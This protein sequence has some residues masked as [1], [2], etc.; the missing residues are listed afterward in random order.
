MISLFSKPNVDSKILHRSS[1][2]KW[3]FGFFF[4]FATISCLH[5][6]TWI[7]IQIFDSF[8]FQFATETSNR[9]KRA[10]VREIFVKTFSNCSNSNSNLKMA[11]SN[12]N[13]LSNENYCWINMTTDWNRGTWVILFSL[14]SMIKAVTRKISTFESLGSWWP[15]RLFSQRKTED[16]DY[17]CFGLYLRKLSIWHRQTLRPMFI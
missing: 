9:E 2:V 17:I 4:F 6:I 12:W 10:E 1:E 14:G 11:V 15:L 3:R 5:F 16:K 7:I 13:E 8:F